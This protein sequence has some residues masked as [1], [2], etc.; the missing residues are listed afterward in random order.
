MVNPRETAVRILKSVLNDGAYSNITVKKEFAEK[1]IKPEDKSLVTALVYG[2]LDRKIT[3]DHI[4]SKYIKTRV[5]K[6]K[7]V[8]VNALR[9]A[10][11]QIIFM[12]KIPHSAAVNE[13]VNIVK[14][15]KERFNASFVNGVLRTYLRN[16]C[17]LPDGNDVSSLVIRFSCPTWIVESFISDYGLETAVKLLEES[18]KKPPV[19]IRVNTVKTDCEALVSGLQSEGITAEKT[20][21]EGALAINSAIDVAKTKAFK[22]GLFHVEDQAS[23]KMLYKVGF[24]ENMR[25]LDLCSAPGGK[26]FTAAQYLNNKGEIIACD[27]YEHRVKLIKD[28]AERLGLSIIKPVINDATRFNEDFGK[29]DVVLCDVPCSGLGVIRRKPEIKYKAFDKGEYKILLETQQAILENADKYL[30]PGGTLVYST[31]TLKREENE[32]RISAF[33]DKYDNYDVKYNVN[34]MPHI[35]GTDGFFSAI[36]YKKR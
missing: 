2:V 6:I 29:F 15:S 18:L 9:I 1:D 5:D 21:L 26:A 27:M 35:D 33:L 30:K 28:G 13:S 17:G 8:T 16:P 22:D 7:P 19:Q 32:T 11:Y 36:L 14:R 3:L 12:D 20:P 31:C 4:I 34:Y 23:Q 25:V 24:S 10:L